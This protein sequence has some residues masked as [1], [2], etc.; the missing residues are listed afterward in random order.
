MTSCEN[1]KEYHPGSGK[2]IFGPS[3]QLSINKYFDLSTPSMRKVDNEEKKK[4]KKK[5]YQPSGA[6]G[7]CSPPG[8]VST[9]RF[10]GAPVNF[11]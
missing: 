11:C 6:G 1:V 5:E 3:R 4:R 7:I 9:P 10:L 8:K 2:G